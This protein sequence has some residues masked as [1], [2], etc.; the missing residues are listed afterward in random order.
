MEFAS[1]EG[2]ERAEA[3]SKFGGGQAALAVEPAEKV[4]GGAIPFLR[5]A[6]QTAGDEVAIGIAPP[7][8]ARHHMVEAPHASGDSA[9]TVKAEATLA[10]VDGPAERPFLQEIHLLRVDSARVLGR[11]AGLD[12]DGAGGAHLLGQRDGARP[13]AWPHRRGEYHGQARESKSVAEAFLRGGCGAEDENRP[14]GR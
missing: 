6:L 4:P 7:A 1:G 5:V 12:F 11:A 9:Q 10:C 14:R 2:I 3:S 13:R 8:G